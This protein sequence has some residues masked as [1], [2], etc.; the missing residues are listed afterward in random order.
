VILL[1]FVLGIGLGYTYRD[2]FVVIP[3][4]INLNS[5]PDINKEITQA[6]IVDR[7]RPDSSLEAASGDFEIHSYTG[8]ITTITKDHIT[9]DNIGFILTD[10]TLYAT[11]ATGVDEYNSPSA[12]ET[13][14]TPADL[15]VGDY[16]TVYTQE[17]I[18]TATD[19]HVTKVQKIIDSKITN[20]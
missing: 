10:A 20:S 8:K 5:E 6:E 7:L 14:I 16:I 11:L 1:A 15:L 9:V 4:S 12:I 13:D 19:K 2:R 18:K 3:P 17:N